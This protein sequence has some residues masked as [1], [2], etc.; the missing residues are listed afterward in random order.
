MTTTIPDVPV[1]VGAIAV[2]QWSTD[3]EWRHVDGTMREAESCG[4]DTVRID[5]IGE[6]NR[7][8]STDWYLTVGGIDYTPEQVGRLIE[9]LAAA[10]DELECLEG[11]ARTVPDTDN[12]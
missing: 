8:G 6:Q 5:I 11:S 1:P 10:R 9:E 3:G 4:G 7:D 12:S 2:D